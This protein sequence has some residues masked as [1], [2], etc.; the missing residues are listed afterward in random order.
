M[1]IAVTSERIP[2][3]VPV[4]FQASCF[5]ILFEKTPETI[6][7]RG[8]TIFT[9]RG[10]HHYL[11][12][13]TKGMVKL[14]SYHDGREVL[15][16]YYHPGEVVNCE[17]LFGNERQNVA[18]EAISQPTAVKK[19]PIEA[20]R[21]AMRNNLA[22]HGEVLANISAS[23]ARTKERLWRV[24]ML[25]SPQRVVHFL[26]SHVKTAGRKVGY[27]W[28]VQPAL[29]HQEMSLMAGTGRQTVT[30]VLNEL[31]REGLVHFTRNYLIVRDLEALDKYIF[32]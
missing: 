7:R 26:I 11:W 18:A 30:T 19:I 14:Y 10:S 25:S 3:L 2:T 15:E 21:Q 17:A 28:V 1:T 20:V 32:E 6:L 24:T 31:K 29:T 27:E 4:S 22:L 16:D 12:L 5:E 23:L 13:V 9:D 8:E